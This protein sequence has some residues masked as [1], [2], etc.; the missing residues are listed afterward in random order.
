MRNAAALR[1]VEARLFRSDLVR[2]RNMAFRAG[3]EFRR[4]LDFELDFRAF[5]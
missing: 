1:N 2:S 5:G 3:S 4:A